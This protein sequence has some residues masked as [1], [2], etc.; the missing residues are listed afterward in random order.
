M[1]EIVI[2]SGKG[3]TGKTSLVGSFA[4]LAE[5]KIL[6]DCDVDAADLHLLLNPVTKQKNAFYSGVKARVITDKCTACGVCEEL[7]QFD[8]VKLDKT[9]YINPMNCEG[10]GVCAFFCPEGAISLEENHCGNWLISHTEYGPLVHAQ[11][12]AGEE[13][14]GKLVA[15][16]RKQAGI[17]AIETGADLVLIDGAPG[18]GCPV[19]ASL[20]KAHTAV[21]VTEPTLSGL[22]DLERVLDLAVHFRVPAFVCINKWDLNSPMTAKIKVYCKTRGI[23]VLGEIPFDHMVVQCQIQGEPVVCGVEKGTAAP[24]IKKIW[25]RLNTLIS[26]DEKNSS[27]IDKI[28]RLKR[29][30]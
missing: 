11:L 1:R 27:H 13:N 23:E 4:Y 7:C 24:A 28:H 20:S 18:I 22:H 30:D 8:S 12:F 26:S 29:L 5:N 2:L 16:V 25:N 19:I 10:C 21:V 6:A 9:A 3:G 15:W 14:S 17:L